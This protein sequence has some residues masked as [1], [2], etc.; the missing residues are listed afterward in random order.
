[1]VGCV[2]CFCFGNAST[3]DGSDA[4]TA[5]A[6]AVP[7][8]TSATRT[9][10]NAN[11]RSKVHAGATFDTMPSITYEAPQVSSMAGGVSM[12]LLFAATAAAFAAS[13]S[14][15]RRYR[16]PSVLRSMAPRSAVLQDVVAPSPTKIHDTGMTTA[17]ALD[18]AESCLP[19][20]YG[21]RTIVLTHGVGQH[22]FDT[23]GRKYLDF[24]S[25][26]AVNCLGHADPGWVEVVSKQAATLVHT[27]NMFLTQPQ[28]E[29]AHKLTS[30]SFADRAFFSNSGTEANE[31]ALKFALKYHAEAG[32]PRSKLVAFEH[33]FHGRTLGALPLTWKE[34]YRK[35]YEALMGSANFLP[36]NDIGALDGIDETTAAVFIEPVQGEGGIIPATAEFLAAVRRRCDEVGAVLVF[37]EVQCGLG[38]TGHLFAY[39]LSGVL[40]DMITLAKPLAAGLPIGAVLLSEKISSAI[41][42]G[43]HGSTFAG[44][45]FVCAAASYT[46]DRLSEE[47]FLENVRE[48]GE[49]LRTGLRG[50][51]KRYSGP[52]GDFEVRGEGLL[53]GFV[54]PSADLCS[55][56]KEAAQAT[57]LLVLTAGAGDVMRLVPALTVGAAEVDDCLAQLDAALQ[58]V[59]GG[60][61]A[62]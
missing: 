27:S 30:R 18:I 20:N 34:Q 36:Y 42:P 49:Q 37:D 23:E 16:S 43:D 52:R 32:T 3:G 33:A 59:L 53:N 21:K 41:K 56:V 24:T 58:T 19:N 1:L 28:M 2:M 7:A 38:R 46:I 55:A 17:E 9:S 50:L 44:G 45:P 6:T 40:P 15:G 47:S 5:F 31:G 11:L 29:L 10:T 35:P 51:A 62:Q 54:F 39:Q 12:G 48:R 22:V 14:V 13:S 4:A 57:G 26:I 25:G 61:G 60:D 8:F